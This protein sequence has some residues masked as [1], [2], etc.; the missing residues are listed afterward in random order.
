MTPSSS[1]KRMTA[2]LRPNYSGFFYVTKITTFVYFHTPAT[3]HKI[4][5]ILALTSFKH[6]TPTTY[7]LLQYYHTQDKIYHRP[8][9]I[10]YTNS[11]YN[12]EKTT[13]G[14]RIQRIEQNLHQRTASTS[15]VHVINTHQFYKASSI[16][17]DDPET[18]HS[19]KNIQKI[20][21][22]SRHS[23]RW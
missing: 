16:T 15:R 21:C 1:G 4:A 6:S 14:N 10:H 8:F 12:I 9:Y 7:S 19:S 3:I 20:L 18:I 23:T 22:N 13:E 17:S 2:R 5:S 11:T